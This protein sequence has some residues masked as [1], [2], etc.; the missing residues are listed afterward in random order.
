MSEPLEP[1]PN[2]EPNAEPK[3]EQNAAIPG[4]LTEEQ[5]DQTSGAANPLF[6]AQS[7]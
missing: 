6:R 3:A 2:E 1:K 5:L 7:Y 4:E